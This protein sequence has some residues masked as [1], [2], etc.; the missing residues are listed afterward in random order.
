MRCPFQLR[1]PR[2][3]FTLIELLVVIAIIAILIALLVPAVQKVREAAARTQCVNNLKQI[4]LALQSHHDTHK[5]FPPAASIA[6]PL[7]GNPTNDV[8]HPNWGATWVVHILPFIEQQS[9]YQGYNQ[10]A[11]QFNNAPVTS[12]SLAVFLCPSDTRRLNMNGANGIVFNMARGNYGIN[13]GTGLGRNNNV[14][15]NRHRLGLV[16][17]RQ[18][19]QATMADVRDGTSNT[20]AVTELITHPRV[21]DGTYGVWG[22]SGAAYITAYN[23]QGGVGNNYAVNNLPV[24]ADIQT[25]NC[26]ARLNGCK[27]YTPHCDNG[28]TGTEPIYGCEDSNAGH[29]AR[30]WHNG[31]SG[32]NVALVDGSVRFVANAVNPRVWLGAFS[33]GGGEILNDW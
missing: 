16:H 8:R 12:Q 27:S 28:F 6:N 18:V 21:D 33:V 7:G 11:G 25:P 30:S 5:K 26:D 13:G 31:S 10:T 4:A 24:V 17:L 1:R 22:Y 14:F 2:D 32:V 29:G 20:V 19:F 15:N 9:L 23:D 3:G